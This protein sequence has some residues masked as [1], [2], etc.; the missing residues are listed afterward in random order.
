VKQSRVK[1]PLPRVE[2]AHPAIPWSNGRG[3]SVGAAEVE[4]RGDAQWRVFLIRQGRQF[5]VDAPTPAAAATAA[6]N[7]L[8]DERADQRT[9]GD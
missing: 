3:F 1:P 8:R 7:F 4:R 6:W 2:L 9:R 5:D